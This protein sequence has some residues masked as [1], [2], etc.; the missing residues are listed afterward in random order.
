MEDELDSA[1]GAAASG[2]GRCASSAGCLGVGRVYGGRRARLRTRAGVA[3]FGAKVFR[4]GVGPRALV[5]RRRRLYGD[6]GVARG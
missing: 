3:G 6:V 1:A 5:T 2:R 4:A